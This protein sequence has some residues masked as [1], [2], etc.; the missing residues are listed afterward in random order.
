MT[1]VFF[2]QQRLRRNIVGTSGQE[3]PLISTNLD[4]IRAY[5]FEIEFEQLPNGFGDTPILTV[6]AKQVSP[7]GAMVEE[8]AVDRMNDKVFYPG[9]FS[10]EEV[11]ITFDNLYLERS[12]E[13]LFNWFLTTHDS[14]QGRADPPLNRPYA[15]CHRMRITEF[16]TGGDPAAYVDLFGVFPKSIRFSEKNYSTNEFSTLEVGFRFDFINYEKRP[17]PGR[18]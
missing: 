13:E 3:L 14:M 1:S 16:N 18:R 10:P 6:A 9:K 15:K 4:S 5:N 11:T 12:S 8:I 2:N 17:V 7:I